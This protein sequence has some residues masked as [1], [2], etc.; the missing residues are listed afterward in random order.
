MSKK[1]FRV[2]CEVEVFFLA[3]SENVS[4]FDIEDFAQEEIR[5]NGIT[6]GLPS[7]VNDIRTVPTAWRDSLPH[8]VSGENTKTIR[9]IL[10]GSN[11]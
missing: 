1:L 5:N 6:V 9:E 8:A 11:G 10:G 3:E 7:A 2:T 4:D